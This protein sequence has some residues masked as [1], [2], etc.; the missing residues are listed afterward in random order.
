MRGFTAITVLTLTIGIG[1]TTA[2]FSAVYPILFG[3]LPYPRADR[4][5]AV[6]ETHANG[7]RSDGTFAMYRELAERARSFEAV[8]VF[9]PW[10]PTVTGADTPE[11]L[12]GQRVS[13]S[14]F[15]VLGVSPIA[16][17]DFLPSDDR[18]RGLHVTILSN[19]LWRPAF[20]AP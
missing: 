14:Y 10:S 2:I 6:L 13:A 15:Q 8:A 5:A 1:G 16:G 17:R 11:R 18:F 20:D 4:V 9:K 3:S 19:A 7:S 12:E